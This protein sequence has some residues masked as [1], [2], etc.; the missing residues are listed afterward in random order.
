MVNA[1]NNPRFTQFTHRILIHPLGLLYGSKGRFLSPENLV[2][3]SGAHFPPDTPTLSGIYAA[4]YRDQP[5]IL[6]ALLLAG[7]FWAKTTEPENIYVPTP[8]HA[9]VRDHHIRHRLVW[10]D[11]RWQPESF[12]NDQ[13]KDYKHRQADTW[14]GLKDWATL[15]S[16]QPFDPIPV[17]DAPWK[18]VP[19]LHPRLREEERRSVG[20]NGDLGSLFLEYG[21]QLDPEVCLVYLS[22]APLPENSVYRFGGEG[23]LV[24]ITSHKIQ[25]GEYVRSLLD[26]PVGDHFSLVCPGVWGSNRLSYRAPCRHKDTGSL[27]WPDG[28]AVQALLTQRPRPFRFRMGNQQDEAGND[29]HQEKQPKLLSRGRYAVPSGSVYVMERSL[30]PWLQWPAEQFPKEGYSFKRWGCGLALPLSAA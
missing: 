20:S 9:W 8:F 1:S 22:N 3:R 18:P 24:Q 25:P 27:S 23:H 19:H 13:D 15:R 2:G 21:I 12:V 10:R 29:I 5:D 4:Q 11:G 14:I 7:P 6:G 16:P 28:N 17:R 30:P 26:Q